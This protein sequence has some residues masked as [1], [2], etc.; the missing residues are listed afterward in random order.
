MPSAS[1]ARRAASSAVAAALAVGT[2]SAVVVVGT[3]ATASAATTVDLAYAPLTFDHSAGKFTDVVGNGKANG[4]VVV[5]KNV[6]PAGK[7]AIDAVVTTTLS[8][9]AFLNTTTSYDAPGSASTAAAPFQ[10]DIS[11]SGTNGTAQFTFAFYAAGTYTLPGSGTPVVLRNVAVTSI[12][13]DSSGSGLQFTDFTGFQDYTMMSAG[14]GG[15]ITAPTAQGG[16]RVRF[17]TSDTSN[18]SAIPQ[19][20]VEVDFDRLQQVSISVGAT[21]TSSTNYFGLLFS[22]ADW[23][24]VTTPTRTANPYNVAPTTTSSTYWVQSG[25][26]TVLPRSAFGTY[27]DADGN[28]MAGVRIPTL[29]ANGTFQYDGSGTWQPVTAGQLVSSE[30]VDAGLLRFSPGAAASVGPVGFVVND[31]LADSAGGTTL[32]VGIAAQGQAITFAAPPSTATGRAFASGAVASSGLPVTLTSSTNGICTASGSTITTIATGTCTVQAD[33]AGSA[34]YATAVPVTRSF[35]VVAPVAQTVTFTQPTDKVLTTGPLLFASGATA[36]SGLPVTLTSLT[37]A[38]CSTSAQ[39]I[40]ADAAGTC[41]VQASQA[42]DATRT[43]ATPVSRSFAVTATTWTVTYSANGGTGSVA[44]GTFSAGGSTPVAA[45]T[46]LGRAGYRFAG[47]NTA[48]AG[49]GTAY[50]AGS[51]Y[52]VA[53]DATLY[54]QWVQQVTVAYS[55][56]GGTGSVTSDTVDVGSATTIRS[57]APLSRTGSV[58]TGWSTT[59]S[60]PGT[61]RAVGSSFTPVASTTLY[62]RWNA[63]PVVTGGTTQTIALHGTPGAVTAT[64]ADGDPLTFSATGPLPAG[65]ALGSDGTFTGTATLAGTYVATL[66]VDDGRTGG[67]ATAPLTIVVSAAPGAPGTAPDD[68]RTPAGAPVTVPVLA[69]DTDPSGWAL[70]VT[71][72]AP[73]AHGTPTLTSGVVTYAPQPGW[74]GTDAF[75]YTIGDGHGGVAVGTV[76]VTVTPVAVAD[77]ATTTG[78]APVEVAVLGNDAGTLD[79]TTVRI[80][81]PPAHGTTTVLASGRVAYAA[82][83]GFAGTD[84]FGYDA[85]DAAGSRTASTVAVTVQA[86]APAPAA[87]LAST[88][89]GTATQ[90]RTVP[91]PSG[92]SVA[93]LDAAG[94]TVSRVE[95]PG[96]GTYL[97]DPGT[98]TISFVPAAGFVGTAGG[99]GFRVVDAYGQALD[100]TYV[101]TVT[102]APAAPAAPVAPAGPAA[103]APAP[104]PPTGGAGPAAPQQPSPRAA[105]SA[106][107]LRVLTAV[108]GGGTV[109]VQCSVS[110]AQIARCSVVLRTTVSGRQVVVGSGSVALPA[111]AA[112][113]AVTVPV[114]LTPLGR[115]LAAQPGGQPLVIATSVTPR[116]GGPALAA[117]AVTR[118][119]AKHVVA[120]RPVFFATD[121]W[122]I[123]PADRHYLDRLR[124]QLDG[125][126]S[127]RCVGSTDSRNTDTYNT[128]LGQRRAAAVCAYL[129]RGRDVSHIAVTTG[130]SAPK[131][132]NTTPAGM[133]YNRRTDIALDY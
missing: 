124:T 103:P 104:A 87:P 116:D 29:P 18:S 130:E 60:G 106:P 69:N 65:L 3:A 8:G 62:A 91:V 94:T 97:L 66:S 83:P 111:A 133:A 55:A 80:L 75:T 82:A 88:G 42:G 125:V 90:T 98:G 28:P 51:T 22:P 20:Q 26:P 1:L 113:Q 46:G 59:P 16:Q 15:K 117:R 41:T 17:L 95:R 78:T 33:Q 128:H 38:V 36:S 2:L 35:Q 132:T 37:P 67:L 10:A 47:W 123:S 27:A 49:T 71:S 121:S 68:V 101:P 19:D 7:P 52:A 63:T 109:P 70:S 43:A 50:A 129:L 9:A 127:V 81:T 64:D 84:T 40:S 77:T 11:T 14:N 99:V 86:P 122:A 53:A 25:T 57:G 54:A 21:A 115:T 73:A 112:A 39:A 93:L 23:T 92:G 4:D 31:G 56:N 30:D 79:P 100:A 72:V 74:S 118:V 13:L 85:A 110:D 102:A 34:S 5:Y 105:T 12:D 32:T 108:A 126:T 6:G 120:V 76:T 96:E 119:V 48:A 24:G 61:A 114:Q 131:A 89:T 58:F 45:G 44:S 107:R